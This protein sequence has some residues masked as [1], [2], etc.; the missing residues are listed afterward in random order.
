VAHLEIRVQL[1]LDRFTLEVDVESDARVL[2]VFGP[3]GAGKT[4]LV[5]TIAGLRRGARGRVHVGATAWFDSERGIAL[6]P[7]RRRVGYVPQDALLFPHMNVRQNL[8][9]G[10]HRSADKQAV[11]GTLAE[12]SAVLGLEP[13]WQRDVRTLSG[14]ERQRVAL[15]RAL[16]SDP[17]LLLLDEPLSALDWPLRRRLL[18][19]L[20]RVRERFDVPMLLVSHDPG[21][22]QALCDEVVALNRGRVVARGTPQALLADPAVYELAPERG[23]ENTLPCEVVAIEADLARVRV[24]PVELSVRA[25]SCHV[26]D[27]TLVGVPARDV[28]LATERPAGLS[29]RNVLEARVA[30]VEHAGTRSTLRAALGDGAF[31]LLVE[32]SAAAC[33]ELGLEPGRSV[34]VI[35]KAAS[36]TLYPTASTDDTRSC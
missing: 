16:C 8:L 31:E 9:A 5:E 27:T 30:G 28:L 7:E 4:S 17:E 2:G 19:F 33:E 18:P 26:G 20:R 6:A 34:F 35:V 10:A 29:A 12:A 24:G 21:E 23:L 3:S 14:G 36:C 25:A 1:T 22:V 11:E 32:I 13:L 15:G